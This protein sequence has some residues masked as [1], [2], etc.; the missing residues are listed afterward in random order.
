MPQGGFHILFHRGRPKF[1]DQSFR[2][3]EG[4]RRILQDGGDNLLR[5]VFQFV[6]RNDPVDEANRHAPG[7]RR[8]GR[9]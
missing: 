8:S 1:L 4:D 3:G 6:R 5:L 7:R 9:R 2:A